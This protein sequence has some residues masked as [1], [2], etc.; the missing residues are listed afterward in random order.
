M[1]SSHPLG[2]A[3][4]DAQPFGRA[5]RFRPAA[6]LQRRLTSNVDLPSGRCRKHTATHIPSPRSGA[7]HCS[8][9]RPAGG[10]EDW[11]GRIPGNAEGFTS[12]RRRA[13]NREPR[14]Q[15][16]RLVKAGRA[17][18]G[19]APTRNSGADIFLSNLDSRYIGRICHWRDCRPGIPPAVL[20]TVADADSSTTT[21]RM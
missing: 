4:D 8:G 2:L 10:D 17:L 15:L 20:S 18:K 14:F 7:F 12:G 21:C 1:L 3:P 9:R 11:F 6:S 19:F 13:R 5:D 16:D